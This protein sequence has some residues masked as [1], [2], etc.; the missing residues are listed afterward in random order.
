MIL[1]IFFV[2]FCLCFILAPLLFFE[3]D[4]EDIVNFF[5]KNLRN[6]IANLKNQKCFYKRIHW[7][8]KILRNKAF[9]S[10][11]VDEAE[12]WLNFKKEGRCDGYVWGGGHLWNYAGARAAGSVWPLVNH[13]QLFNKKE[14][15]TID[16]LCAILDVR[17]PTWRE[18]YASA[19]TEGT[20][21]L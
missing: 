21:S 18:F 6:K 7:F 4:K 12:A 11:L 3:V 15:K 10:N 8:K 17:V 16:N 2:I 1:L 13:R 20:E 19:P 14:L 5:Y 9:R